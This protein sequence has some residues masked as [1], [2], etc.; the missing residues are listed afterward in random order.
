MCSHA[1]RR[2]FRPRLEPLETRLTPATISG[3]VFQDFN[4]NGVQ[5]AGEPGLAGQ[6]VYLDLTGSGSLA[7]GDPSATTDSNGNYQLTVSA[8]GT[9][10]VR[11]VLL[12]GVLLD[13]PRERQHSSN[14]QRFGRLRAE[15][16]RCTHEH[17]GTNQPAARFGFPEAR[18]S[19]QGLC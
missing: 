17:C 4:I 10:S 3:T 5:D 9:Y 11:Q 13:T 18:R 19:D 8:T 12:G 15:F 7:P 1:R 6:E 16:R 2:S 14:D